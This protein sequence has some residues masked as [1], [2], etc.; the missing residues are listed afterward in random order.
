M[1]RRDDVGN[2]DLI[3]A[4]PP[5]YLPPLYLPPRRPAR[6]PAPSR[7]SGSPARRPSAFISPFFSLRLAA[8][9]PNPRADRFLALSS[10]HAAWHTRGGAGAAVEALLRGRARRQVAPHLE[11]LVPRLF[12]YCYDPAP[13]V[14]DAMTRV[15]RVR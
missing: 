10:H 4:W 5:L 2:P 12:R 6:A 3:C 15:W 8:T 11:K 7:A 14:R 13:R 9:H 1:Q